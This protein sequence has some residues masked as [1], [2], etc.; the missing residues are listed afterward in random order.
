MS[1]K[2]LDKFL[3]RHDTSF[4]QWHK[5]IKILKSARDAKLDT[6]WYVKEGLW[7]K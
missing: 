6:F 4:I 7:N 3:E 1:W 2:Q 5:T